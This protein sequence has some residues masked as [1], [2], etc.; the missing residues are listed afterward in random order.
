MVDITVTGVHYNVSEK[1][2]NYV[3]EKLSNLGRFHTGLQRLHV[4]IQEGEKH[5]FRV[6]VEMHL[7]SNHDMAAHSS[8]E[9]IYAS[10]DNVW[11]KC[12]KQ[13]RRLHSKQSNHHMKARA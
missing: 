5:G 11:D 1:V 7:P 9:T 12:S 8:E 4:N 3:T 13:L 2:R 10:V 6:D